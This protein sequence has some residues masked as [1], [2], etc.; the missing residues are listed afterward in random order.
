MK[1]IAPSLL[2][3]LVLLTSSALADNTL[4]KFKGGIGVIP[5]SSGVGMAPTAAVVNRNI[6]RG[7]Q[8]AGQPWVIRDL[9]ATVK[10]DGSIGV[11]GQGLLLAGGDSIGFNAGASV[12]VTLLCAL[13]TTPITFSA[14]STPT[15]GVPLAP[16]GDFEIHEE[17]VAAILRG[18]MAD[19]LATLLESPK[20][21]RVATGFVFT[22]GP[23]WH[24]DDFFYF[25]DIRQSHLHR[26]RLGKPA[27]LV[28]AD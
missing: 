20:A 19:L 23:L 4:A 7:V 15:T 14:H 16:D 13:N 22:E 17:P 1:L 8:P 2:S 5:V 28:R 25:V 18:T 21:E 10:T 26:I 11:K 27:E 24:P 9:D 12:F 6:V 3:V